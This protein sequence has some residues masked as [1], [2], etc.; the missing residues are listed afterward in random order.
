[1]AARNITRPAQSALRDIAVAESRW[2]GWNG[3]ALRVANALVNLLLQQH[4]AQQPSVWHPSITHM[5]PDLPGKYEAA[6]IEASKETLA[7]LGELVNKMQQQQQQQKARTNGDGSVVESP[8]FYLTLEQ[9]A[10]LTHGVW[11]LYEKATLERQEYIHDLN[12]IIK[13]L[14]GEPVALASNAFDSDAH[15]VRLLAWESAPGLKDAQLSVPGR[16]MILSLAD[17]DE[18]VQKEFA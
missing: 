15:F 8:F 7:K 1:M 13:S 18:L 14:E 10:A 12:S 3:D 9:Y 16:T 2:H 4:S 11:A 5:F 17:F 6:N